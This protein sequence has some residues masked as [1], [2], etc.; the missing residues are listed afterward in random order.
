MMYAQDRVATLLTMVSLLHPQVGDS[1]VIQATVR[2][3][4]YALREL[5]SAEADLN[6]QNQV[7]TQLL[8]TLHAIYHL[9]L[10]GSDSSDNLGREWEDRD[11]R[12]SPNWREH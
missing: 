12:Y 11:H 10:G 6:L 3:R 9:T 4:S 5:V 8:W 2:H 7:S 1:A